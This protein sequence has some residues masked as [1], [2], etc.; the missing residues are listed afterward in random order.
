MSNPNNSQNVINCIKKRRHNLRLLL[1][2]KCCI[3]GYN[4]IEEALDFHHVN[5]DEKIFGLCDSNAATKSL[6]KQLMEAKKCILVCA[7][8]HRGI[9]AGILN[10]PNNWQ[11]F[12]NDDFAKQLLQEKQDLQTHKIN[13]CLRC[14]KQINQQAKYCV[15]CSHLIARKTDRPPREELKKLIR[16]IPF[17]QIAKKYGVTDNAIRKWC[18]TENLPRKKTDIQKYSDE[19]WTQL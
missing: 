3:C 9:H 1:G 6:E 4:A 12:Y 13:Y 17:T 14:G 15:E 18:D 2:G 16:T 19:E 5:P 10:I 8:C 7:N 11:N